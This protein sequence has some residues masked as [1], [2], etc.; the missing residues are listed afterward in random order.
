MQPLILIVEDSLMYG[1]LLE[2]NI[3]NNLGFE[4][5]WVKT[6][7]EAEAYL[8]LGKEI[9]L[10]L[11]DFRLPDALDGQIIDLFQRFRV[12]SVVI[13]ADFSDDMQELIWSK[14]IIDY[15][16][17][18]GAHSIQ[19]ILDLIERIARNEQVG[20]LIVDDSQVARMHIRNI[21]KPLRFT[22]FDASSGAEAL[23]LLD[24]HQNIKLVLT[25]Y[26]MPN[27]DGFELTRRI[28]QTYSMDRLSIIGLSA[29][30]NHQLTVKFI[31]YGANDFLGKPFLSEMLYCRINLNLKIVEQFDT[32][33]EVTLIDHLTNVNNRRFLF[34][35]GDL[36]FEDGMR[37]GNYP[38]VAMLDLDNFK[39][40]NDT[41]G[42]G[43][44]DEVIRRIAETLQLSIRKSDV[45]SRYGGEEFCI[46]C[47]NM[48]RSQIEKVFNLWK[49]KVG[50]LEYSAGEDV[51]RVTV[52]IGVCTEQ[53]GS[54]LEMIKAADE[55]LYQAKNEGRNRVCL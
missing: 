32:L 33:R 39:R 26:N 15:V 5:V 52:S 42:H 10:A 35:A 38:V 3:V 22:V 23:T 2:R 36:L 6:Y 16:V 46:V 18:E 48:E 12:P 45:L 44:G 41:Y 47:R 20:I 40:I 27:M 9:T 29:S 34:E 4:T 50:A 53:K 25:D 1:K 14:R 49:D 54:F 11:L 13:T 31:K 8:N 51:F 24:Q 37:S 30:G 28:R 7:A 21:L 55:K 19:Y 17:K 43:K